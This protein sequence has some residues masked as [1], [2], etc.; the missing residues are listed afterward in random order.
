MKKFILL[1]ISLLLAFTYSVSA[2]TKEQA[3]PSTAIKVT[4]VILPLQLRPSQTISKDIEIE[5]MSSSPQ[6]LR[7]VFSDFQTTGE[8]GGYEFQQTAH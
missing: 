1:I 5:N 7:A 3:A 8:D 2:Q 4:P 6:P